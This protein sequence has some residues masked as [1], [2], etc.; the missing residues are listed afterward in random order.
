MIK[1][2]SALK[3]LVAIIAA[4]AV[5]ASFIALTGIFNVSAAEFNDENPDLEF[6]SI[7]GDA[8]GFNSVAL[9]DHTSSFKKDGDKYVIDT[10]S[11]VAWFPN[12]DV[13][14]A[15]KYYGVSAAGDDYLE[16]TVTTDYFTNPD[17]SRFDLS[18]GAHHPS[19]GLMF[20]SGLGND[21]AFIYI[22]VRDNGQIYVVYRDPSFEYLYSCSHQ[23]RD[24]NYTTS[25]Y[26]VQF[27]MK[28]KASLVQIEYKSANAT[29]WSKF[30]P[31]KVP[32]FRNGIYAGVAAHSGAKDQT[33]HATFSDL[34]MEGIASLG[35]PGGGESKPPEEEPV[36]PDTDLPDPDSLLLR[37]TFTDGKLDN[38]PEAVNN[39]IWNTF[40]KSF[41][42][43][44]NI[45]G[46]RVLYAEYG[47]DW[48][49]AGS[50]DWT[51]YSASLDMSFEDSNV[52]EDYSAIGLIVRHV[53]NIFYGYQNY[54]VAVQNGYKICV[55]QNF[56][57][58][59]VDLENTPIYDNNGDLKHR[60]NIM[61]EFSLREIY[62]DDDFTL[63]GDG[64]TH[65]LKVD[66]MDN[67]LTIYFDGK[68]IGTYIDD[69][70]KTNT[71]NGSDVYSVNS[72]GQVGI[73]Y[74]NVFGW[75]DNLVVRKL[76]DPLGGDYDNK[77][78][79]NWD[80]PIPDY[81]AEYGE[82]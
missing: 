30:T 47:D 13:A 80:K 51:D 34:K 24:T 19:T 67:T 72:M 17:G 54:I 8:E 16:A 74:R 69:H 52:E 79:G 73:I 42:K 20:R 50:K 9:Y 59:K 75:T 60:G 55:Y 3:K 56:L 62:N 31:V 71:G 40:A 48:D 61:A 22:H 58:T 36:T 33:L 53:P 39:P 43:V 76:D 29:T 64:K 46:N 1:N 38:T 66:C 68:E 26:P 65:N 10:N 25:D 5:L 4:V 77:I 2:K 41:L 82:K 78:C 6:V 18:K 45:E 81:I 15:Y 27:R 35:E 70:D 12:D 63:F 44:K 49:A 37:E 32:S 28:L 23:Y 21:A 14:F 57:Q 7:Q 11:Y